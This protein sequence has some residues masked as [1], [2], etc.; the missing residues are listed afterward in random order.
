MFLLPSSF[1]LGAGLC[2][3]IMTAVVTRSEGLVAVENGSHCLKCD[4]IS[5]AHGRKDVQMTTLACQFTQTATGVEQGELLI[6]LSLFVMGLSVVGRADA[7]LPF[8][9]LHHAVLKFPCEGFSLSGHPEHHGHGDGC[10]A[11][12]L[13]ERQRHLTAVSLPGRLIN[14]KPHHPANE[15]LLQTVLTVTANGRSGHHDFAEPFLS[16]FT[17]QVIIPFRSFFP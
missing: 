2:H 15:V 5:L 8:R 4:V 10:S 11:H 1:R 12:L 6:C 14:G 17:K 3:V 16:C 13:V 9:A 7:V